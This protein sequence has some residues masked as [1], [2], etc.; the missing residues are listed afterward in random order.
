MKTRRLLLMLVAALLFCAPTFAQMTDEAIVAYVTQALSQGKSQKQIAGELVAK[1]VPTAQLRRILKEYKGEATESASG[2]FS[3]SA[4]TSLEELSPTRKAYVP[5]VDEKKSA[6]VEVSEKS[7]SVKVFGHD[8]FSNNRLSFE[9]NI[10]VATPEDYVLGPGDEIVIDIWGQSEANIKKVISPEGRIIVSQI[11]A[12]QLSG[13]TISEASSKIK[14]A[15]SKRYSGIGGSSPASQ[16]SVTLGNIRSI[17]VNVMGEVAVPGT[18]R[19][20]S[21]SSIFHALYCAGGVSTRGSLRNV[22]VIRAGQSLASVDI[23]KFIFEGSQD[24]NISLKEGDVIIV[25]SY[26]CLVKLSGG[27]K[28]PMYYEMKQGESLGALIEYA[29]GFT[30]DA[31]TS[32]VKVVRYDGL[33]R[34]ISTVGADQF[35]S[36]E[37]KDA[38]EVTVNILSSA[39]ELYDN[40]VEIR[41][42]VYRPGFYELGG[43]IATV[44]QLVEHAGGL[45]DDAFL[46]RA[47]IIRQKSDLSTE[48][49]AISIGAI[50]KGEC[51]DIALRNNDIISISNTNEIE[52][53][54]GFVING[55]VN[56]PG[57]YEYADNMSIEDLILLSGGLE[58]GASLLNVEVARR[59]IDKESKQIS[60]TVA[61]V[62]SFKIKDG[63]FVDGKPEFIL[64]PY[65]VVSVRK[66]PSF[67]EQKI[68]TISGEV[69][70]PGQ[71][72]ITDN[73]FRMSDLIERAGGVTLNADIRGTIL[74]RKV[75]QYE[76]NLRSNTSI[77][78][79]HQDEE[80]EEVDEE[81]MLSADMYPVG[82]EMDKALAN[83]GGEQDVVLRDGDEIIVP[84]RTNTVKIQ[85]EVLYP[86]TVRYISGKSV[87]YYVRQAG[88]FNENA[89]RSKVYVLY[90]N[91]TASTGLNSKI[92]P[93]CEIIV[94]KRPERERLNTT[95][96][97]S[98][99]SSAASIAAVVLT[100]I[101]SIK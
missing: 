96:I 67:V 100:I 48:I 98:M 72:T 94:P 42:S 82:V 19:L 6:A 70:Y 56:K 101:N 9:P 43:D 64:R 30:G 87:R 37:L 76:K 91:G 41:G 57:R 12:I 77:I 88:G 17:Q 40:R 95:E 80:K 49:L 28:R 7:D 78:L 58:Q 68:V 92:E 73:D 16:I 26:D 11:G 59:V 23:Y 62:F 81:K 14:S 18:Y 31:Y 79:N 20:S 33:K 10:N 85:G 5:P 29:G 51:E 13:L 27:V 34:K 61:Q 4:E 35:S 36:F 47:Q 2:T 38:D 93:G 46:N 22:K 75:N 71:Y 90:M 63:L 69:N 39:K 21:F 84:E 25:P 52:P 89:R 15:F 65:D 97:L 66:L 83:P 32:D 86:N 1:G 53:K 8:I 45:L 54:G 24:V 50:M 55:Y 60:D 44:R 99:S 74:R 3:S